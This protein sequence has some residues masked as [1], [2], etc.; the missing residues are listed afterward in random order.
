[1]H[2]KAPLVELPGLGQVPYTVETLQDFVVLDDGRIL[3]F[4]GLRVGGGD[5]A[6]RSIELYDRDGRLLRAWR[7]RLRDAQAVFDPANPR[8]MLIWGE[9]AVAGVQLI[10]VSGDGYP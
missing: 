6:S 2:E 3:T 5:D 8:R 9:D 10:E 4:G 7:L 1:M